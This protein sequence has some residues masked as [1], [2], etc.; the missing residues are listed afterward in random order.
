MLCPSRS[1]N[2]R[3]STPG[4]TLIPGYRE[5]I[6]PNDCYQIRRAISSRNSLGP[7][8]LAVAKDEDRTAV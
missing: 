6:A 3:G 5:S 7:A 4:M 2:S 8:G 1:K